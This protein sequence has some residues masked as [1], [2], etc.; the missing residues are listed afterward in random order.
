M[1]MKDMG[2]FLT[3]GGSLLALA[4]LAGADVEDDPRS[5]NFG[6][7]KIGDITYDIWGGFQ[8]YIV[9][10]AQLVRGETKSATTGEIRS[11]SGKEFPFKTRYDDLEG[12]VRGKLAPVPA[13]TL[14]VLSGKKV[15]GER[16]DILKEFKGLLTPL[17]IKD[18]A[19]TF[20]KDGILSAFAVAI[21]SAFGVGVGKLSNVPEDADKSKKE[22]Q[23]VASKKVRVPEPDV[24]TLKV[25]ED[26]R[27]MNKDEAEKFTKLRTEKIEN[28]IKKLLI[29]GYNLDVNE[30]VIYKKANN[31]TQEELKTVIDKFA[32]KAT[33]EAKEEL[34]GKKEKS[35]KEKKA[36][37]SAEKR[38]KRLGF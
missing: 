36:E 34:F 1:A 4:A 28:S 37:S 12:F 7:I 18:A 24:E 23:F 16:T 14:N 6:K 2:A 29:K 22:W 3:I 5:P 38:N 8:Q 15:T 25:G 20:S 10:L 17:M 35:D 21:P 30:R 26:D 13:A 33:S 27:Y 32:R 11:L 31:L 19:E 9:E